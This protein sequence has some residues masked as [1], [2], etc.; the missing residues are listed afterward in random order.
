MPLIELSPQEVQDRLVAGTIHLVDVREAHEFAQARIPGAML[1]P[2][3]GFDPRALPAD[4]AREV[5]LYCRSGGRTAR[6]VAMC[7]AAGVAV[8]AHLRGG[9]I[10][11]VEAG[12]P[13]VTLDPATGRLVDL[14]KS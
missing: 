1:Y 11:W 7:E 2:M 6:A 10:A 4:G 3:S 14:T 5:V 12:L 8:S 9:L 13:V